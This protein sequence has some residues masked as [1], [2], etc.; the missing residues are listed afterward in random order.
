MAIP[1][2]YNVRHI[3]QR[4]IS[5]L[6]TALGVA[7]VVAIFIGGLALANGFRAALVATGSPDNA[8]VLR[9]GADSELSSGISRQA[10][11]IIRGIPDVQIGPD[12]HPLVSPEVYVNTNLPRVGQAGSSNVSVRGIDPGS[13][14]LRSQVKIVEGRMFTPGTA[15]VIVGRRIARRFAHCAIGDKLR[16]SSRDVTVVGHFTAGGSAFESEIWG[17]NAVLMPLFR[18]DVFQSVTFRMRDPKR[19]DA[20]KATLEKDPRLGVDVHRERDFYADQ[21]STLT[22]LLRIAGL[23]IAIIMAIGAI[24]SAMN[25]MYAAVGSRTREIAVLLTLGFT[26]GSV[27]ASFLIESVLLALLGGTIGCLLALPIN[28]LTTSTTNF[29]SFSEVAFAFRVTP[30]AMA[31]GLIFAVLMGI[32]G[33][34]LPA[35]RASRQRLATSLRAL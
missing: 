10:A 13:L 6:A 17:D 3:R 11:N 15:E 7:L 4:P 5:T 34:I 12:G 26:P 30:V 22:N 16:F 33:G 14:A 20:V 19:F 25:T 23:F 24:F 32:A 21:S 35:W 1:I 31:F 2:A 8:V 29:S 27:M 18:G 9:K 28:G